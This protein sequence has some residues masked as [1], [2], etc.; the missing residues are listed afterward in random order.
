MRGTKEE[1]LTGLRQRI[2]TLFLQYIKTPTFNPGVVRHLKV[3]QDPVAEIGQKTLYCRSCQQYYAST[4]FSVSSIN[5]K[6]GKCRNCLRLE[7][8]ANKRSDQTK[9]KYD[10]LMWKTET[11]PYR[12]L[13]SY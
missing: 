9:Y 13:D 10:P 1:N 6:V 5:V 3:P 11:F 2:S 8:I 4:E 12:R 7:N